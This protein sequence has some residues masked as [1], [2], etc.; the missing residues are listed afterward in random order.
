LSVNLDNAKFDSSSSRMSYFEVTDFIRR[1][2]KMSHTTI[3]I[4]LYVSIE[5]DAT[6]AYVNNLQDAFRRASNYLY[7]VTDGQ[8]RFDTVI[9]SDNGVGWNIADIWVYASNTEWPRAVANGLYTS[10]ANDRLH[11][12]RKFYGNTATNRNQSAQENPLNTATPNSY[13][14]LVHELGHYALG[15][16]DEY[17][18]TNGFGKCILVDEYGFMES[19]Y[20]GGVFR[21]EMSSSDEYSF[22]GCQN[23]N[24]YSR[25]GES[26]WEYLEA[27][28]EKT[29]NEVFAPIIMPQER[30]IPAGQFHLLG[31]NDDLNNLD[32]NVGARIVFPNVPSAPGISPRRFLFFAADGTTPA[33]NVSISQIIS[34]SG[35]II[36]QGNTADDGRL[37]FMGAS[38]NYRYF[39]SGAPTGVPASPYLRPSSATDFS[40]SYGE[41]DVPG[42]DTGKIVLSDVEGVFPLIP[43]VVLTADGMRY[44]LRPLNQYTRVPSLLTR[45][46]GQLGDSADMDF[47]G[48]EYSLMLRDTSFSNFDFTVFATD[49]GANVY[50]LTS[51]ISVSIPGRVGSGVRT[52]GSLAEFSMNLDSSVTAMRQTLLT[53]NYPPIRSG[54]TPNQLQAGKVGVVQVFPLAPT[55]LGYNSLQIR[56]PEGSAESNGIDSTL[57][58]TLR[59]H[60]WDDKAGEWTLVGG[61][62]DTAQNEVSAQITELGTYA[63]FTTDIQTGI[64]DGAGEDGTVL[65]KI[66][67]V[68]QNYPNP[69]NPTTVISYTL[70]SKAQVRVA[71]YNVLGQTVKIF[72]E[73]EQSAG[74]Y[75]IAWD[76]TDSHGKE[77]SSGMYF[78]KVTA[79]KFS[80]SRKMVLLK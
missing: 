50:F 54:L 28:F 76:A 25:N 42:I 10:G 68:H 75:S 21:S 77:V 53:T 3:A 51:D 6:V 62:V 38:S 34:S 47:D 30:Q 4:N 74:T 2:I 37:Y 33:S 9:I 79:G 61:A 56:Y 69:F 55:L 48:V 73:G 59:I 11:M 64:G 27:T 26:C 1:D 80:A 67:E 14:T 78:Y 24:Q 16:F 13:R 58:L 44:G 65:P 70:P 12:P 45:V 15:F 60:H 52:S 71:I 8:V 20:P 7:D 40:W 36:E 41:G 23:T 18:F 31:P 57:E 32:V 17:I 63:L 43:N 19:Q 49:N 5:F 46:N 29:Y 35:R 66:F 22:I 72:A 39:A